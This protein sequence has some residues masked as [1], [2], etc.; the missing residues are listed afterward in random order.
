MPLS[1]A[2][3]EKQAMELPLPD[4]AKLIASLIAS[5]DSA[6]EGD[7]EAAWAEEVARRMAAYRSGQ[8]KAV[9]GEEA[10]ADA[11]RKLREMENLLGQKKALP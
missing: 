11:R 4:R 5:L 1:L 8:M 7:V 2:E 3:L 9:P 6:D 10:M